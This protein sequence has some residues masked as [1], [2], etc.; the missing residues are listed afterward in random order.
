MLIFLSDKV[1]I[2]AVDEDPANPGP[3]LM[4]IVRTP[5]MFR[6]LESA[7]LRWENRRI[8]FRMLELHLSNTDNAFVK[9]L[10][11]E[12]GP[13]LFQD[14]YDYSRVEGK[15]PEWAAVDESSSEVANRTEVTAG[16]GGQGYF[17]IS[18]LLSSRSTNMVEEV[19]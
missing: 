5:E 9:F 18:F 16:A 15:K 14:F 11:E 2:S 13:E 4:A 7:G 19:V 3:P 6:A 12:K 10:L 1:N 8:G 17:R